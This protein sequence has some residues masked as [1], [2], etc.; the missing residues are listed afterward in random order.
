M[1]LRPK[2]QTLGDLVD[3]LAA[4]TPR[5]EAIVFRGERLDYAA[6]KTRVDEFAKALLAT[7]IK[8]GDRVA[9]L[10][11]NRP[12][13]I[14]AAFGTA[15]IGAI[16]AALS[17]FSTPRELG[18]MLAHSGAAA[19]VTMSEFRGRRLLDAVRELRPALPRL[20]AVV[21]ID[22]G[23]ADDTLSLTDFLA[24][25]S[26]ADDAAAATA[27]RRV[28]PSDIG[29]ILYTSGSTAAPKGVTLAHGPVIANG[30]D[31]GE[32]MHLTA[33][34][35]VWLA[36]P[37]FWS[38]GSANALPALLT[39][40][41]A[42]VLQESFEPGEALALIE[43]ERCSV[44]YGMANMARALRQHPS[45]PGRRL[46]AM[47]T[48]LTIGPP[49][50]IALTI[51]AL[52]ADQL[53]N[54]YGATETYGNCAVCDAHDPLPL[55]LHTQG[56]PLPGMT[57][58]A[59]DPATRKP[60]PDGEAGELAVA[61][62]V[63]PGYFQ[64][65]DLNAAAFDADG[66]FLTGDLGSIEDGR[67]RFRGRLKEMI[68]TGGVN[69]AP[70]EVEE[71]LLQHPDIVQAY[72]VGVADAA[73]GEVVAAAIELRREAGADAPAI[74]AFCRERLASYKVP[75]RLSFRT[76][77]EFPRTATGKI[78]KPGLREELAAER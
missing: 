60:L 49:E 32:R 64:A 37:L 46:G 66:Y 9:L 5:A 33:A 28:M 20:R 61:G 71:V 68:K 4:A 45:H 63:T 23:S 76:A 31:I 72:V 15:K 26:A 3:E 7:G 70:L 39:H 73:K 51:A 10:I 52:G 53:C 36:V 30:F 42:I 16:V 11:A 41:G 6:L 57:I 55:R 56:R 27:Q 13:W 12:E 47:R 34:D 77:A 18:W 22:A 48:G 40:G 1:T 75:A 19:L 58:R 29:Y 35:R 54:V 24:R 21:A 65:P 59:V 50:D 69:V 14:V 17:T 43:R 25:G 62:Y 44:Y 67:V 38:F 78:H 2:S 8:R 74:L